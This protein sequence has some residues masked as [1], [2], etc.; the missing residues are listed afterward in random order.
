VATIA[1][2]VASTAFLVGL[3]SASVDR[4]EPRPEPTRFEPAQ[5]P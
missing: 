2:I 1:G 3:R 5:L 4:D